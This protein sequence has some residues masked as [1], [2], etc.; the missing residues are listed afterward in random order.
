MADAKKCDRCGKFYEKDENRS[1]KY[2]RHYALSDNRIGRFVDLCDEC[3]YDLEK[4]MECKESTE[5]LE[6]ENYPNVD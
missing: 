3:K 1:K 6:D 5:F 2:K 4:F